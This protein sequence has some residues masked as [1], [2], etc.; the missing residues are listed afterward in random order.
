MLKMPVLVKE[1]T[2]KLMEESIQVGFKLLL[3]LKKCKETEYGIQ[4]LK[5][6]TEFKK[7][8]YILNLSERTAEGN[9]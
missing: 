5:I 4:K 9:C 2:V 3:A 7:N 6:C 8:S 1:T